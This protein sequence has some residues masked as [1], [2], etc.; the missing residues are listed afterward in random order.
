M[1]HCQYKVSSRPAVPRTSPFLHSSEVGGRAEGS[2]QPEDKGGCRQEVQCGD[3]Q[4]I[5]LAASL[6]KIS[7]Y[8]LLIS[9]MFKNVVLNCSCSLGLFS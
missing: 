8:S 4:V 6:L 1:G 7:M 9:K 3:G 2:T 5:L